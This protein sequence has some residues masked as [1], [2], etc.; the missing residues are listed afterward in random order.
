MN[1]QPESL[2]IRTVPMLNLNIAALK[3]FK[4]INYDF[5]LYNFFL[6]IEQ[7]RFPDIKE[8]VPLKIP[9]T[10]EDINEYTEAKER[11]LNELKNLSKVHKM[12]MPDCQGL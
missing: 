3:H 7:T 8:S 4:A 5:F 6:I 2:N 12:Q 1:S 10:L 11:K 9:K